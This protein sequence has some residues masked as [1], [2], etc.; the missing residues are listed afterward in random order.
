MWQ[1]SMTALIGSGRNLSAPRFGLTLWRLCRVKPIQ[2][3]ET[4]RAPSK[5]CRSLFPQL[6]LTSLLPLRCQRQPQRQTSAAGAPGPFSFTI[7]ITVTLDGQVI[8]KTVEK[9]IVS[10]IDYRGKR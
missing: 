8:S 9:R 4:S 1:G 2:R 3:L 5:T 7:P 6:F 10:N